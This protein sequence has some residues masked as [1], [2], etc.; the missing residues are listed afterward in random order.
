VVNKGRSGGT[1][2]LRKNEDVQ[3]G[4]AKS[5]QGKKKVKKKKRERTGSRESCKKY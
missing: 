1:S 4:L 2:W 3:W 5:K